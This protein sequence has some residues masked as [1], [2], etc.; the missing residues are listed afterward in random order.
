MKN[1]K[2]YV[3]P[4]VKGVY[5]L[6]SNLYQDDLSVEDDKKNKGIENREEEKG[7]TMRDGPWWSRTRESARRKLAGH[8]RSKKRG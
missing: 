8:S 7:K 1:K 2:V 4:N 3:S 6:E 5:V